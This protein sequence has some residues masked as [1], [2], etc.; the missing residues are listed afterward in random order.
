MVC[1]KKVLTINQFCAQIV[2][3]VFTTGAVDG[4]STSLFA[5]ATLQLDASKPGLHYDSQKP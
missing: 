3:N 5:I 2:R 1:L 4:E